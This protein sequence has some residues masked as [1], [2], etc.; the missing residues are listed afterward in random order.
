MNLRRLAPAK[1]LKDMG[2]EVEETLDPT[3]W[4]GV[5][6]LAHRIVGDAVGC[7]SARGPDADRRGVTRRKCLMWKLSASG[8]GGHRWAPIHNLADLQSAVTANEL[9]AL[10]RASRTV[11][12]AHTTAV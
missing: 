3:D 2:A 1:Q 7:K 12:G 9:T 11:A 8:R 4:I 5:E 6:A 10:S